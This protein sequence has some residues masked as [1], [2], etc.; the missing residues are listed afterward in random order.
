M[1]ECPR[2]GE[3]RYNDGSWSNGAPEIDRYGGYLGWHALMLTTGSMLATYPVTGQSWRNDPFPE[4]VREH[5]LSRADGY[6]LSDAT[7]LFPV[8]IP[9]VLPMPEDEHQGVRRQDIEILSPMLKAGAPQGLVVAGSWEVDGTS[10]SVR[11]LLANADDAKTAMLAA[12]AESPFHRWLPHDRDVEREFGDET[13][14]V[15]NWIDTD[16]NETRHLD[17]H[18][19]YGSSRA[20]HRPKPESWLTSKYGL[21]AADPFVREWKQ[22]DE[23]VLSAQ[24]WGTEGGK[25]DH[26]WEVTGDRI[27]VSRAFSSRLL[28]E[29]G[30]R[31][32]G[33]IKARKYLKNKTDRRT[34]G[35]SFLNRSAAF[36]V[37]QAGQVAYLTGIPSWVKKAAESMEGHHRG[38][39]E[40]RFVAFRKGENDKVPDR[41]S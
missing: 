22:G 39:F 9:K 21:I 8:D 5:S 18:D 10:V 28:K 31:L 15:R 4:F 33:L 6:W 32:V 7:D 13:H 36:T 19:P 24:A 30:L 26:H 35:G 1:Y 38:T 34:G 37:D 29:E 27:I 11:T 14:S 3:G 41:I 12:M 17:R 25:G 16:V 40:S 20:M 2:L 23:V